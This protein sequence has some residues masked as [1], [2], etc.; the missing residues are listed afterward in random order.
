MLK[1]TLFLLLIMTNTANASASNSVFGIN[2]NQKLNFNNKKLITSYKNDQNDFVST[3]DIINNQYFESASVT[4]NR[5]SLPMLFK[6]VGNKSQNRQ[7]ILNDFNSV[8]DIL[9]EKYG[10]NR[11][12][13]S[14]TN[15]TNV[16]YND[17]IKIELNMFKFINS[18]FD[19]NK[20]YYYLD[21]KYKHTSRIQ[22]NKEK[23]LY[24]L[25]EI[26]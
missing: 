11:S 6:A 7:A 18:E 16:F 22:Q 12:N 1:N 20:I 15:Y 23:E 19:K 17:D 3:I 26:L 5:Y 10:V 2:F 25:N 14:T 21:I 9:R 8:S 24:L 4:R 13:E